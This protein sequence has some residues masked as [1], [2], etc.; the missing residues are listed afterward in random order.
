MTRAL[1]IALVVLG[2]RLAAA[3][4]SDVPGLIKFVEAP[5]AGMDKS[6]WKEKRRDAA[7]RLA[8]SK[9][10]R[11]VPVLIRVAESETFDII[12]EIAIEGLGNLGDPSAVPV[13]QKIANDPGRE[14]PQRELAKK[15]L[16]K[17][18]ATT[19]GGGDT[20]TSGGGDTGTSGGGDTGTSGGGD[21][22]GGTGN[23]LGTGTLGGTDTTT[24]PAGGG[25]IGETKPTEGLPPLPDLPDDTLAASDRLTFALGD[26]AL[27]YD[28][29]RERLSFDADVAALFSHRIERERMAWGFDTGAHLVAGLI[30]PKGRAQTRGTLVDLSGTGE[31]RF[32]SGKIYG[33][34]KAAI[35]SQ[36]SYINVRDQNAGNDIND[37]RFTADLQLALGGGFGR[38]LD[39]GGAIR[40]RRLSRTL[41]ANKA[42][43][44]PIDAQVARKLQL[45]WWALR[46]ERSAYRALVATVAIL[47]EAGILLVE[48][49]AGLTYEIMNVLHD[50][51][52]FVRPSGFDIQLV[53]G[54]GYLIRPDDNGGGPPVSGEEGRVEQ[55]LVSA[56]YGSQLADDTLELS[57]TGYAR[58]RLF[59]PSGGG[60]DQPTPWFAG[61][62][63]RL[64]RFTYG[65]HGDPFG[66]VD[67]SAD[68]RISR[69]G[70]DPNNG[71]QEGDLGVRISGQLGFTYWLNQASGIRLAGTVAADGGELF[72]G[73]TL[74]ATYGFL[75]ATFAGL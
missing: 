50:T 62:T 67:L 26:A 68:V 13:L 29:A 9:D 74:S 42:L 23:V 35:G 66:A 41:D 44:K 3:Q 52:L 37:T 11:A 8:Q 40:V 47:R 60:N 61:A 51:Q 36:I 20:G 54:E 1:F 10:K 31:A 75:D 14:K 28:T 69:D 72:F 12:G 53:F 7:R 65:E 5:P 43:G 32:Y 38:V 48:P 39:V 58:Y 63:G 71:N 27:E 34:G 22:N 30:N 25:L 70:Q 24:P 19:T 2:A 49:D 64:R 16:G 46:R 17:L 45:T 57:G 21:T 73:A 15:A 4:P 33:I 55:L 18:G 6:T 56:G 59:A